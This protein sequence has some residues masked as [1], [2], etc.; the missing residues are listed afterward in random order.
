MRGSA[1][2]WVVTSLAAAVLV[3]CAASTH[4][5]EKSRPSEKSKPPTAPTKVV[6]TRSVAPSPSSVFRTS[7]PSTPSPDGGL[8]IMAAESAAPAASAGQDRSTREPAAA[9]SSCLEYGPAKATL[10]GSIMRKSFAGPPH[11]NEI[12]HA[13]SSSRVSSNRSSSSSIIS[14]CRGCPKDDAVDRET[15]FQAVQLLDLRRE[16]QRGKP[17]PHLVRAG[18]AGPSA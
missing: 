4:T 1:G 18:C 13:S 11:R 12:V 17:A 9:E 5:S 10:H 14:C 3:A 7:P 8:A 2:I 15:P 16:R 6:S